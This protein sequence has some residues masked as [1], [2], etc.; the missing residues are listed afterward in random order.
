VAEIKIAAGMSVTVLPSDFWHEHSSVAPDF[1]HFWFGRS[2]K[3]DE[4]ILDATKES[5]KL[6]H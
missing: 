2:R 4:N 3:A 1:C 6:R 5:R